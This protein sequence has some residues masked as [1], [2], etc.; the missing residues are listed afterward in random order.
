MLKSKK[1]NLNQIKKKLIEKGFIITKKKNSFL[2]KDLKSF[3]F[4]T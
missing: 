2:S 3:Y 4:T 1:I